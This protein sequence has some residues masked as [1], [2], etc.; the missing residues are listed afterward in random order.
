M[1][2]NLLSISLSFGKAALMY[3]GILKEENLELYRNEVAPLLVNVRFTENELV[4][5]HDFQI[6]DKKHFIQ[7]NLEAHQKISIT[8]EKFKESNKKLFRVLSIGGLGLLCL[9]NCSCNI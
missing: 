2:S 8:G 7:L 1:I 5:N 9:K 6:E 4:N 3:C